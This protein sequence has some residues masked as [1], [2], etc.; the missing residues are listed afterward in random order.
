[1]NKVSISPFVL[2]A[3][4]LFQC[5][6]GLIF[7]EEEIGEPLEEETISKEFTRAVDFFNQGDIPKSIELFSALGQEHKHA[8]S[9]NAIGVMYIEGQ[10]VPKDKMRARDWLEKAS[11]Y[12][13]RVADY[14]LGMMDIL[15]IGTK[16]GVPDY[17]SGFERFTKSA[18]AGLVQAQAA[19]GQ[20]YYQGKG[21]EQDFKKALHW[22]SKAANENDEESMVMTSLLLIKNYSSK[23]PRPL[24]MITLVLGINQEFNRKQAF[25]WMQRAAVREFAPAQYNLSIMYEKGIGT[26]RNAGLANQYLLSAVDQKYPPAMEKIKTLQ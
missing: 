18:N 20:L 4:F 11:R 25:Y 12:G 21:V 1:M 22:Y 10:K 17:E 24:A 14:N 3:A 7:S 16:D 13:S 15:G 26:K 6:P 2:L 19:L 9:A 5:Y 8:P 23:L